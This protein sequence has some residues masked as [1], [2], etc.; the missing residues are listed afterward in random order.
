[1]SKKNENVAVDVAPPAFGDASTS[2]QEE[3]DGAVQE[4]LPEPAKEPKIVV[5]KMKIT[6]RLKCQLTDAEL[7][8]AGRDLADSQQQMSELDSELKEMQQQIKSK[9]AREETRIGEIT[10]MIRSGYTFRQVECEQT[11]DYTEGTITVVRLDLYEQ[12]EKETMSN[13]ER[14]TKLKLDINE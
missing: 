12:V 2:V 14:Q 1:M 11:K 5:A 3:A 6:R 13:D 10:S 8:K 9:I 7:L 4:P